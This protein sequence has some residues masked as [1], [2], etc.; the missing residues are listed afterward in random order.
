MCRHCLDEWTPDMTRLYAPDDLA[1]VGCGRT[2][3]LMA[4]FVMHA[5]VVHPIEESRS[6]PRIVHQGKA[7][8]PW[9]ARE[10]KTYGLKVHRTPKDAVN[11]SA[12]GECGECPKDGRLLPAHP[13]CTC[14]PIEGWDK[15]LVNEA[16]DVPENWSE[17]EWLAYLADIRKE[18][19]G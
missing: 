13:N 3:V 7:T 8:V 1:C 10:P 2:F 17:K 15:F 5:N 12:P 6:V 9:K 11:T 18:K 4:P 16:D 19:V 14:V